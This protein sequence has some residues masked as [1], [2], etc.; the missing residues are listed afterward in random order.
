MQNKKRD[1]TRLALSL[2][3]LAM[4]SCAWAQSTVEFA[5]VVDTYLG[6]LKRSGESDRTSVLNSSG[7]ST[8]WWGFKGKEDLGGGLQAQFNLTGFF[9][10]DNGGTGRY[11]ADTMFARD[12]NVGLSGG[13]GRVSL[14]RDLA[15]NFVPAISLNPFGG[16]FAFAPL[17]VHTQASSG[18]YVSQKWAA[19]VAGDTGWSNEVMYV[20]PDIGGLSASFFYQFGEQAGNPGKNNAGINAMYHHGPLTLGAYYQKVKVNY[21]LDN[22][23][24][25]SRV[26]TF[27]PY[28]TQTGA[29]YR[30]TSANRQ[31]TW[32]VG[33]SYDFQLVKL[34]STYQASANKL[35]DGLDHDRF[36]LTSDTLQL[37][38][39]T[40]IGNGVALLSW[41]KTSVKA[42]GNYLAHPGGAG[43]QAAIRRNT[44]SV[45]Y[46]YYLSKRTDMYAVA[47]LD[48]IT[49]Q[50]S[51]SSFGVG[52]RHK[53]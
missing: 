10:P 5:G 6:S 15:P 28:N 23:A 13:F 25:D 3:G 31:D 52:V 22:V 12:A 37:G 49:D 45:G 43:W 48:R 36:D 2:A 40:P 32:F 20:T 39:S 18:K 53:F 24:G 29:V 42:D 26:F 11:D 51:G 47:M 50:Q 9:R 16:S 46:D 19:T 7:M 14:G 17:L 41:A 34:F 44:V 4:A 33:A 30:L 8:S 38:A 1:A 27:L 35:P 21:P